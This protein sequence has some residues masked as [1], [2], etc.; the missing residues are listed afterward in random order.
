MFEELVMEDENKS[1]VILISYYEA[2]KECPKEIQQN[3]L[4]GMMQ[5]VFENVEPEFTGLTKALWI[6][7]KANIDSG[8]NRYKENSKNGQ[9]GGAPKGNK[10]AKK[11]PPL[12]S[13][14]NPPLFMKTTNGYLENNLNK[15]KDKDWNKDNDKDVNK[16]FLRNFDEKKYY[17]KNK[18]TIHFLMDNYDLDLDAAI[19]LQIQNEEDNKIFN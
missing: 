7:I 14:N 12:V 1:F 13:E 17:E 6:Q 18:S 5:Y 10:N 3:I 19:E 4:M 8:L 15:D 16:E 11:Q 2:I 9:K